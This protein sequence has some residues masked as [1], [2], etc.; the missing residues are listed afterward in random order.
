MAVP[1]LRLAGCSRSVLKELHREAAMS[2][3]SHAPAKCATGGAPNARQGRVG[4]QPPICA[5]L[6]GSAGA[7]VAGGSQRADGRCTSLH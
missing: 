5:Q 4:R 3:R 1:L 2:L 7:S 6:I